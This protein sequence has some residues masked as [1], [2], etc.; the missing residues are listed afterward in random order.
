[1]GHIVSPTW[2][3]NVVQHLV[4][5]KYWVHQ[6]WQT[7]TTARSRGEVSRMVFGRMTLQFILGKYT[8]CE[9]ERRT[10]LNGEMDKPQSGLSWRTQHVSLERCD[11]LPSYSALSSCL[12]C[13]FSMS[14][15]SQLFYKK[16]IS[17][18]AYFMTSGSSVHDYTVIT[19]VSIVF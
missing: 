19:E 11:A 16:A 13:L 14:L 5:P 15:V 9:K 17:E 4:L 2:K 8:R 6:T 18:Y 10:W 12:Q 7:Q 1:M 3:A